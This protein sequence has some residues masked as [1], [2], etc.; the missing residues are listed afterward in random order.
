M[1][2]WRILDQVLTLPASPNV[3]TVLPLPFTSSCYDRRCLAC[4]S[5][6]P[7]V[8]AGT[9][10]G[11]V[12]RTPPTAAASACANRVDAR[13]RRGTFARV[14][15]RR[16]P[17]RR[18]DGRTTGVQGSLGPG[19]AVHREK[20]GGHRPEDGSRHL[21]EEKAVR[22]GGPS[23]SLVDGI[24]VPAQDEAGQV[25]PPPLQVSGRLDPIHQWHGDVHQP[26]SGRRRSILR[27]PSSPLTASS[28]STWP[29]TR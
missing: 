1:G 19:Q 15:L 2:S 27:R 26:R 24:V 14:R 12:F 5:R 29:P 4:L 23:R 17:P 3:V 22:P 28:T 18:R 21:L 10:G 11:G 9:S 25:A 16:L 20:P 7:R 13:T 8:Y 6:R